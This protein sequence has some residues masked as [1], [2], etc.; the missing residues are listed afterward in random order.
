MAEGK[1]NGRSK[2]S[3]V[4]VWIELS[5]VSV[6]VISS[7][8][9]SLLSWV[10]Q[11]ET[12]ST[13]S[14]SSDAGGSQEVVA[15]NVSCEGR[16]SC[17]RFCLFRLKRNNELDTVEDV[18]RFKAESELGGKRGMYCGGGPHDFNLFLSFS[19]SLARCSS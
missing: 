13:S 9:S 1:P 11:L 6:S 18:L 4:G 8:V 2:Y 7:S 12:E 14:S 5:S 3:D 19:R 16:L 17:L 15:E 10:R